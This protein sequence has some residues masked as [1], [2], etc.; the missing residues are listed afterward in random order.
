MP[1][2]GRAV[3]GGLLG[4]S[5]QSGK[6]ADTEFGGYALVCTRAIL[7]VGSEAVIADETELFSRLSVGGGHESDEEDLLSLGRI[8]PSF[9]MQIQLDDYCIVLLKITGRGTYL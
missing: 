9:Y 3:L 2:W 4:S 5:I 7:T 8:L 6:G 1:F